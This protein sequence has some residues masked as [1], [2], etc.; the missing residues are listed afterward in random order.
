MARQEGNASVI[1]GHTR[2]RR[3]LVRWGVA[4]LLAVIAVTM[5]LAKRTGLDGQTYQGTSVDATPAPT[6][7]LVDQHGAARTLAD[8]RGHAVL[9][10]F[11]DGHCKDLCP[12]T[13]RT[14][15][16]IQQRL[17]RSA[18]QLAIVAVSADPWLDPV[19]KPAAIATEPGAVAPRNWDFLT[20]SVKQLKPVW[21]AYHVDV[22]EQTVGKFSANA[23]HDTGFFLIDAQGKERLYI[24]S[25]APM[26]VLLRQVRKVIREG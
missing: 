3:R 8:Y 10:T 26:S 24:E 14:M 25:D 21:N 13:L 1:R 16:H 12:T 22:E 23:S 19:G 9:I 11:M 18:G 5:L 20:G 6:F 15:A 17:G 7:H 4:A 2:N